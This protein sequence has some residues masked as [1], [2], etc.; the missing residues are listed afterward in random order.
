MS[1][2]YARIPVL[3]GI[4]ASARND[5]EQIAD[6]AVIGDLEDR[7][8]RVFVDGDND[9]RLAH[10]GQMLD[11]AAM[12]QAI[13]LGRNDF[14]GLPDLERVIAV[15]GITGATRCADGTAEQ[16][17][18][19]LQRLEAF[20]ALHAAPARNDDFGFRKVDFPVVLRT[21]SLPRS[22]GRG[23][24]R[25]VLNAGARAFNGF[26]GRNIVRTHRDYPRS[27]LED[28]LLKALPA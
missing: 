15:A 9:P 23:R 16:V 12:P 8:L 26:R 4:P 22:E 13:D 7:C 28:T 10:A 11:G 24:V 17:R 1:L 27:V 25:D 3:C 2:N 14:A 19:L 18:E 5:V 6:D 20:R 21:T